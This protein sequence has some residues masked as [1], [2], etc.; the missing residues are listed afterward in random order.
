MASFTTGTTKQTK[1]H[2]MKRLIYL[3]FILAIAVSSCKQESNR[4]KIEGKIR[5]MEDQYVYLQGPSEEKDFETI[6]S[7]KAKDGSFTFTGQINVP[8]QQYLTFESLNAEITFFNEASNIAINGH[9][10]SLKKTTVKGSKT[11]ETYENYQKRVNQLRDQQRDIYNKY[12][13]A[14]RQQNQDQMKL[15]ENQYRKLDSIRR[16]YSDKFVEDHPKSVVSAYIANRFAYNYNL[17]KLKETVSGF[18]PSIKD[19]YYVNQL[20]DRI[21]KLERTQVGKKAPDFTMENTEGEPVSLSDFRGKYVLLDFWAAWCSPCRAENPNVV[22][23]YQKYKDEGF[24][25]LG[26]SLDRKKEDWLK[27][28]EKDSLTWTHVSDL[29][30]WNNKASNKYGVMSIPQNYLLDE[31][32]TIVAKNLRGEELHQKLEEIL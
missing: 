20:E 19:S 31:E 13:E 9:V 26:V 25:V 16:S 12:R 15:Y 18:D 5:G 10:D 29:K 30:G 7:V 11:Q 21:T 22:K 32:G 27:A 14:Q 3:T 8:A 4:F 17:E 24:T 23:A 1:Y 2:K 6:D 28:I